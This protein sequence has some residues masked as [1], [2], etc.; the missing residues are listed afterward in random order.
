MVDKRT[1]Y[2]KDI[3]QQ[4]HEVYSGRIN[5]FRSEIPLSVR[6]SEVSAEGSSLYVYDPKGKAASAY[7]ELIREVIGKEVV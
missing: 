5:V 7:R 2:A 4:I 6:A 3:A 1:N